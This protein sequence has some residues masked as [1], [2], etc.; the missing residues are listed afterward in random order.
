MSRRAF[1]R[2]RYAYG[3]WV[4][5]WVAAAVA[6]G[7]ATFAPTLAVWLWAALALPSVPIAVWSLVGYYYDAA[8]LRDCDAGW[9]PDWRFWAA[10]HVVVSPAVAAPM[11]LWRRSRKVNR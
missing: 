5:F 7:M 4:V 9:V 11:Y 8:E 2:R 1:D 3:Y 10:A 6:V